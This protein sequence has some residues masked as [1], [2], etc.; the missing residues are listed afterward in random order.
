[1]VRAR[2]KFVDE[3][4]TFNHCHDYD[5]ESSPFYVQVLNNSGEV[6]ASLVKE[7]LIYI[8]SI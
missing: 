5:V 4:L 6:V 3:L 2:M 1:M 7:Q 8:E